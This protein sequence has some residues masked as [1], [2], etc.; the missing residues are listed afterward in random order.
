MGDILDTGAILLGI[1]VVVT[2]DHGFGIAS[3]QFLKQS[4]HGSLL[5]WRARIG[6]LTADVKPALV[7]DADRVGIVVLAVGTGQP[8]RTAW[9]YR[10]VTTDHVMVAD[11]ELPALAAMPCVNLSGR[12]GLVGADC[13]TVDDDERDF[14]HGS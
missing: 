8:F 5:R 12:G 3:V 14:S 9:L 2:Y 7:A 4:S 1:Q 10:S 13:R 11:T 6:G